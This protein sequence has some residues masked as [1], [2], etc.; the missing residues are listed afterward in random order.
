MPAWERSGSI[1]WRNLGQQGS[2]LAGNDNIGAAIQGYTVSMSGPMAI[3]A[4]V[5][6]VQDNS[7]IGASLGLHHRTEAPGRSKAQTW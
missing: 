1:P 4:I 7:D 6:G 3:R 2:K 5:G